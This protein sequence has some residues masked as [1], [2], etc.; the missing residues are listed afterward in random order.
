MHI[1]FWWKSRK[2][3][4]CYKDHILSSNCSQLRQ[5]A[6]VIYRNILSPKH[7]LVMS[8]SDSQIF[9]YLLTIFRLTYRNWIEERIFCSWNCDLFLK[10]SF[11]EA[12]STKE[13]QMS[14]SD[15]L[16][17]FISYYTYFPRTRKHVYLKLSCATVIT[18]TE[19]CFQRRWPTNSVIGNTKLMLLQRVLLRATKKSFVLRRF[20]RG[21]HKSVG[22]NKSTRVKYENL[23]EKIFP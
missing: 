15:P 16:Q 19:N 11:W 22:A 10:C 4:E 20:M 8:E 9:F 17:N 13:A 5:I 21:F 23:D 12:P 7:L 6:S 14:F 1:G 3:R 2:E 18:N